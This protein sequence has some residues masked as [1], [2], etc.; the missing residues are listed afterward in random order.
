MKLRD[1]ILDVNAFVPFIQRDENNFVWASE[2]EQKLFTSAQKLKLISDLISNKEFCG[3]S[4][5]SLVLKNEYL[6][7]FFPLHEKI[8]TEKLWKNWITSFHSQERPLEYAKD[9]MGEKTGLYFE[10]L[11]YFS[12]WLSYASAFGVGLFL[13]QLAFD[14]ERPAFL[15]AI[16]V[17]VWS[18]LF[19]EFWKRRNA[20]KSFE[21]NM[22]DYEKEEG[23]RP[24]Y[25][26]E[27]EL[28]DEIIFWHGKFIS[29]SPFAGDQKEHMENVKRMR[30]CRV[31]AVGYPTVV[32]CVCLLIA[33]AVGIFV[34]KAAVEG[35]SWGSMSGTFINAVLIII[36]EKIYRKVAIALN[37]WENHRTA[38]QYEDHLISKLFLFQFVNSYIALFYVAFF[39]PYSSWLFGYTIEC[40][41]YGSSVNVNLDDY[42]NMCLQELSTSLMTI[43]L[44]RLIVNQSMEIGLP[45]LSRKIG[46]CCTNSCQI[47]KQTTFVREQTALSDSGEILDQYNEIVIQFGYIV[48]F[49]AVFPLAPLASLI[50]NIIEIKFDG[51]NM[52]FQSKRS[53]AEGAKDIG[54]WLEIMTLMSYLGVITNVC[55]I[56]FT[57]RNSTMF[58]DYNALVVAFLVEHIIFFIKWLTATLIPDK[59]DKVKFAK[60]KESYY[61]HMRKVEKAQKKEKKRRLVIAK[62]IRQDREVHHDDISLDLSEE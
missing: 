5:T 24:E 15:A 57:V 18:T 9:Y 39:K 29:L 8:P 59:P 43:F 37:D 25:K 30:T 23:L 16:L 49:S 14:F 41:G 45:W 10:W 28:N 35:E 56:A 12:Q 42:E 53:P 31:F 48:L 7:N 46:L 40:R 4:M 17:S 1:S 36:L 38:T 60:A 62:S 58:D 54:T 51:Y 11:D 22:L 19:L 52:L 34:F 3:I 55:I 21:W 13:I 20:M 44:T 47:E 26:D 2:S 6:V 50:N 33:A 27:I 32:L 61:K